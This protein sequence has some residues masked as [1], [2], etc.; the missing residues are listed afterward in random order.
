MSLG[1]WRDVAV[2]PWWWLWLCGGGCGSMRVMVP[3]GTALG[4][5]I[6]GFQGT[7]GTGVPKV[8]PPRDTRATSCRPLSPAAAAEVQTLGTAGM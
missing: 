7:G 5:D 4:G 2:A 3:L 6:R 1:W 8:L